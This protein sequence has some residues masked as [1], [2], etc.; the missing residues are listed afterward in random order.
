MLVKWCV[1]IDWWVSTAWSTSRYRESMVDRMGRRGWSTTGR[2]VGVRM[3]VD[4]SRSERSCLGG[5]Y[6][7]RQKALGLEEDVSWSRWSRIGRWS[8]SCTEGPRRVVTDFGP[9]TRKLVFGSLFLSLPWL[10]VGERFLYYCSRVDRTRIW[11]DVGDDVA[12]P[13]IYLITLNPNL[14]QNRINLSHN[15]RIY[16]LN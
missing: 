4:V 2:D 6:S 7:P 12:R 1:M 16:S 9:S 13:K 5:V 10:D 15:I 11:R 8:L 14:F 3:L